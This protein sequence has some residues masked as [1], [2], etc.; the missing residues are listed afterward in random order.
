MSVVHIYVG[1]HICCNSRIVL[2]H[3]HIFCIV[4]IL[5]NTLYAKQK[6]AH[7]ALNVCVHVLLAK[8]KKHYF[9][10]Q[11]WKIIEIDQDLR[12]LQ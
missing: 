9:R 7:I 11:K 4:L 12:E 8:L 2:T 1:V 10:L 6:N 3:F 5:S